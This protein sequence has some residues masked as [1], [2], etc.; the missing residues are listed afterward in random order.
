MVEFITQLHNDARRRTAIRADM[1]LKIERSRDEGWP[2]MDVPTCF[3][4]VGLPYNTTTAYEVEGTFEEV[5]CKVNNALG[6]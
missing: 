4:T 2:D 5:L 6:A 3:I 1:V